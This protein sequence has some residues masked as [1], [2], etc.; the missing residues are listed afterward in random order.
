MAGTTPTPDPAARLST[1]RQPP[2]ARGA[3]SPRPAGARAAAVRDSVR[4]GP[5]RRRGRVPEPEWTDLVKCGL[6]KYEELLCGPCALDHRDYCE[7]PPP[8]ASRDRYGPSS[9]T[10]RRAAMGQSTGT[11]QPPLSVSVRLYASFGGTFNYLPD[12][13]NREIQN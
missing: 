8:A 5:V 12:P 7:E 9:G 4:A 10:G 13:T 2:S 3:P 6:G 1:R 11:N